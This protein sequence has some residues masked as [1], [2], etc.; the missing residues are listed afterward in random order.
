MV[1]GG[2]HQ[3]CVSGAQG[4][5]WLEPEGAVLGCARVRQGVTQLMSE[6]VQDVVTDD[7]S[8]ENSFKDTTTRTTRWSPGGMFGVRSGLSGLLCWAQ[9]SLLALEGGGMP[10]VV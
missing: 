3:H 9:R 5:L 1:L 7:R 4:R 2:V 8:A 6:K 10:G